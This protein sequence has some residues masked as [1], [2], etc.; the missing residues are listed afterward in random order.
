MNLPVSL[1]KNEGNST[2]PATVGF[3]QVLVL[4]RK[5]RAGKGAWCPFRDPSGDLTSAETDRS[6][7]LSGQGSPGGVQST[8]VV[9]DSDSLLLDAW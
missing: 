4:V 7:I 3:E 2:N 8:E 5:K 6:G 1:P 9:L